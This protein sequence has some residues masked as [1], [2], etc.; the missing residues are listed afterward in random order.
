MADR[1]VFQRS[2]T[3]LKRRLH[4]AARVVRRRRVHARPP[5]RRLHRAGTSRSIDSPAATVTVVCTAPHGSSMAPTRPGKWANSIASGSDSVPFRPMKLGAI[6][7]HRPASCDDVHECNA[8]AEC[9]AKRIAR[10]QRP[11]NRIDR[12]DDVGRRAGAGV[13][14]APVHVVEG[15][16]LARRGACRCGYGAAES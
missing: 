14:Q 11:A 1:R 10:E 12:R 9:G 4:C 2:M 15:A 5:G 3:V 8:A 16:Q 13:G 7:C 6:A